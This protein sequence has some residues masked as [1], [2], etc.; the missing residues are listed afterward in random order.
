MWE[1]QKREPTDLRLQDSSS[2]T[3]V[4]NYA[5]KLATGML[6]GWNASKGKNEDTRSE[7]QAGWK[8]NPMI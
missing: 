4:L 2:H 5:S 6:D 1:C 7:I 8:G 3:L